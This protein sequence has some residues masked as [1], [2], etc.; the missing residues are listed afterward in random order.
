[1]F[2]GSNLLLVRSNP[3]RSQTLQFHWATLSLPQQVPSFAINLKP[4]SVAA[5]DAGGIEAY[6]LLFAKCIQRYQV[7]GIVRSDEGGDKICLMAGIRNYAASGAVVASTYREP[8]FLFNEGRLYL[9]PQDAWAGIHNEIVRLAVSIWL[10]YGQSQ[11]GGSED[12][13]EFGKLSVDLAVVTGMV[14]GL[15]GL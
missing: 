8:A 13:G 7:P 9:H 10:R 6:E 1:M 5:A 15:L 11:A 12:K 14:F 4:A 3:V 2:C